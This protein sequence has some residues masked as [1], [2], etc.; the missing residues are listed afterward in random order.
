MMVMDGNGCEHKQFVFGKAIRKK[1][2]GIGRIA[3][4]CT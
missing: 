4:F 3:F 2:G 1:A